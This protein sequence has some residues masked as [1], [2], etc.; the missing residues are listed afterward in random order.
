[1]LGIP[2]SL[3][4]HRRTSLWRDSGSP[5]ITTLK[6][7]DILNTQNYC[8]WISR[9]TYKLTWRMTLQKQEAYQYFLLACRVLWYEPCKRNSLDATGCW[10]LRYSFPL[11]VY[12][13]HRI[14]GRTCQ[15]NQPCSRASRPFHGNPLP[16]IADRI[17]R[18][19]SAPCA[20]FSLE[21]WRISE[22]KTW[23]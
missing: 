19:R 7:M 2:A 4:W 20:T 23:L 22:I 18:K 13:N 6:L 9:N 3:P 5:A 14:L 15:S 11:W 21:L 12:C 17:E 1:M 16:Q 10:A 8:F